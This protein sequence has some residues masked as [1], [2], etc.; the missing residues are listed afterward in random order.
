MH[1]STLRAWMGVNEPFLLRTC[2]QHWCCCCCCCWWSNGSVDVVITPIHTTNTK[3]FAFHAAIAEGPD[4]VKRVAYA[5]NT[6]TESRAPRRPFPP[7]ERERGCSL[8][9]LV[10]RLVLRLVVA[11]AAVAEDEFIVRARGAEAAAFL[12]PPLR[13]VHVSSRIGAAIHGPKG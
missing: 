7:V 12:V 13:N 6:P 11:V 9:P 1:P 4:P 10:C 3:S 8:P 5:Q 2:L